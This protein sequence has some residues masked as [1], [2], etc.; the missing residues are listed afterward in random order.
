MG[1]NETSWGCINHHRVPHL[2]Y[3]WEPRHAFR[4]WI[5]RS[6]GA[7]FRKAA[8]AARVHAGQAGGFPFRPTMVILKVG[9]D[10]VN[11]TPIIW[12]N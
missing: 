11:Q 10:G 7:A 5:A 2:M 1:S 4:I 9:G 12:V 6:A 3:R 8:D